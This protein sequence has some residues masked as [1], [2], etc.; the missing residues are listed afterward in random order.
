MGDPRVPPERCV[1]R[2]D[3]RTEK[4]R[5]LIAGY[6]SAYGGKGGEHVATKKTRPSEPTNKYLVYFSLSPKLDI[7][8]T[9]EHSPR[10]IVDEKSS[11]GTGLAVGG[12]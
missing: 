11:G 7:R 5:W 2:G 8:R 3:R 6:F 9:L 1:G 10:S 4:S 12:R